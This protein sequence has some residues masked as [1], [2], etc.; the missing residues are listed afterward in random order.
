MSAPAA[1]PELTEPP[2]VLE[3]GTIKPPPMPNVLDELV[4]ADPPAPPAELVT[5]EP[6]ELGVDLSSPLHASKHVLKIMT[7]VPVANSRTCLIRFLLG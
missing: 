6:P 1:P 5:L 3:I 4:A 2:P 7:H